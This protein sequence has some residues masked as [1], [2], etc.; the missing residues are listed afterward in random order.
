LDQL[1]KKSCDARQ[2]YYRF[3]ACKVDRPGD[4][5]SQG[6]TLKQ[7]PFSTLERKYDL[8][9]EDLEVLVQGKSIIDTHV[10]L[11]GIALYTLDE[12]DK[13]AKSYGY[14]LSNPIERAEIQG[15]FQEAVSFV[16]KY[17]LQPENPD[18]LKLDIPRKIVE[19]HDIRELFLMAN[20]AYTGQIE[21]TQ[22]VA[23]RNWACALLK[24]IHT[25]AHIDKDLRSSYFADIQKQILDRFYKVVHRD[26]DGLYLGDNSTDPLRVNLVAFDTKPKKTRESILLKLLH[27]PENV[28]E[29]LFDRVGIRFVTESRLDAVRVVKFLK[30][31]LIIV[32]ANIK[33]SRSRNTLVDFKGL[34]TRVKELLPLLESQE[35]TEAG[36]VQKL[37]EVS[38]FKSMPGENKHSSQEYRAIQ[39][40][41]RQL[42]KLKNPVFEDVKELKSLSKK[43][44]L[45]EEAAR[46]IDRIE[47][48]YLQREVRF[49][50]PFEVQI[51]D[52][53]NY[54][55]N[56][57]G[58]SAHSEYKK[59]QIQ[60]AV[61]RVMG[62]FLNGV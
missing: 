40:T 39:F 2:N 17:F 47:L 62:S 32:S 42:I 49:F 14:D 9:P 26:D 22:G 41:C 59:A 44:T 21:D 30:D 24:V 19:L 20:M 6:S 18:G 4:I 23:L 46:V 35:L 1:T 25:I 13:F 7:L 50:Y 10:G 15:N 33:P 61:R 34:R 54:E 16:R 3:F 11:S 36:F 12:V 31:S 43:A 8:Q 5:V 57:K 45:P 53:T 52:K 60:T 48:K 37:D 28:A 58:R 56:E 29:E 51:V 55:E 27:K 38:E